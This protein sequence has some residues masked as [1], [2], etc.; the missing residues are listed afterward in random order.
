[1]DHE[2]GRCAREPCRY[3]HR[4]IE[5]NPG[6]AP[7]ASVSASAPSARSAAIVNNGGEAAAAALTSNAVNSVSVVENPAAVRL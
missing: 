2:K 7:G 6:A 5:A 3:L 1:M 4:H